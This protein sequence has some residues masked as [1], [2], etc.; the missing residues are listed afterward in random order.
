MKH[1]ILTLGIIGIIFASF[2]Y[3]AFTRNASTM[4]LQ[5][6]NLLFEETIAEETN[7]YKNIRYNF[8]LLYPKELSVKEFDES[9]GAGTI[10]LENI[11]EALGFQIF[12]VPHRGE[13]VSDERFLQDVPSGVRENVSGFYVDGVLA[14][15][16]YSK[17]V[18]L[19]NTFEIWIVHNEFL[20][21]ITVIRGQEVWL[22]E[23]M[24]TWRFI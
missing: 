2:G 8:S 16:F 23:I 13:K 12:I 4:S 15:S 1:S 21:E 14:T 7:E 10:V 22:S 9:N 24:K 20:Y 19:G 18:E 5:L 6:P 3:Y 17:S 11:E